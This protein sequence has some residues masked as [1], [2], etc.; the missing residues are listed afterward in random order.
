MT[1][2]RIIACDLNLDGWTVAEARAYRDAVGVN[3]EY[4]LGAM[5]KA[6]AESRA[7]ARAEFGE[8]VDAEGWTPPKDWVP[9]AMLNLD[10]I[11]LAGFAYIA[12]R[13]DDP[14]LDF[15]AF[16]DAV[17][18]GELSQAFYTQLVS[19]AEAAAA[20]LPNRAARRSTPGRPTKNGTPSRTPTS[21]RSP[22]STP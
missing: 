8:A 9:L 18:V 21:G 1:D 14:A 13:R 3:A 16:T 10:P 6:I 15:A 22:R 17:H 5:Q 7:E 12:A 4:A 20:P 11:H 19:Q 2:E